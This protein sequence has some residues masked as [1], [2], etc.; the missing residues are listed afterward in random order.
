MHEYFIFFFQNL[1]MCFALTAYFQYWWPLFKYSVATGDTT[2]DTA[3]LE[4][5]GAKMKG[6]GS[7]NLHVED[8]HPPTGI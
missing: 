3:G 7:L 5:A 8:S 6:G 2:L 4:Y 1:V